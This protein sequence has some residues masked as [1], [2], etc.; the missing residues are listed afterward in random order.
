MSIFV[1]IPDRNVNLGLITEITHRFGKEGFCTDFIVDSGDWL[2]W[3]LGG[4]DGFLYALIAFVVI[5]YL[6]GVMCAV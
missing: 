6:L 2:G 3:F 4:L 5:D 1:N